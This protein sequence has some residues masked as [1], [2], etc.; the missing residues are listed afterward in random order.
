MYITTRRAHLALVLL[1]VATATL[2]VAC[3]APPAPAPPPAGVWAGCHDYSTAPE[4]DNYFD[5][6]FSGTPGVVDNF[7]VYYSTDGTCS[8]AAFDPHPSF[9]GKTTVVKA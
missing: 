7:V 9:A 1:A 6:W 5:V 8:P 4:F 3:T 2:G